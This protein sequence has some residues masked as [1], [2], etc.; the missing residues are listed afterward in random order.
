MFLRNKA[1]MVLWKWHLIVTTENVSITFQQIQGKYCV[2][3]QHF[4]FFF[5]RLP[6]FSEPYFEQPVKSPARTF[7]SLCLTMSLSFEVKFQ[8]KFTTHPIE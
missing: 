8:N 4:F 7:K 3:T 1:F 2:N 6:Q 5:A